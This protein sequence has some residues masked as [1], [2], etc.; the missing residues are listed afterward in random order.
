MSKEQRFLS[1][2]QICQAQIGTRKKVKVKQKNY[3]SWLH[4]RFLVEEE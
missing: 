1:Q 3:L 2:L 4:P